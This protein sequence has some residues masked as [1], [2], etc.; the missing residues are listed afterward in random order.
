VW[1]AAVGG[2]IPAPGRHASLAELA[3][4]LA[5]QNAGPDLMPPLVAFTEHV[6]ARVPHRLAEE[7]HA[8]ID[9]VAQRYLNLA[10]RIPAYRKGI[11][12]PPGVGTPDARPPIRPC[13][14]I[15]I[16]KDFIESDRFEVRYWIQRNSQ[17]WNPE[18]IDPRQ[19]TFRQL[20]RVLQ[21]AIEH[22]ETAWYDL[23]SDRKPLEIELLL[24]TDLLHT[25]VEWWH[26]ELDTPA[27]TPLCL[28]YR[29]VVRPLDRMRLAHRR[30]VWNDRWHTLW[31]HPPRHEVQWGRSDP[32]AEGL[33]T[34]NAQLRED[35][36]ITT[37]VLG[38]SPEREA[39]HL[40]L[41]SALNTGIPVILWDH[42]P[43]PLTPQMAELFGRLTQ[44]PPGE[45]ADRV[46]DLRREAA[47]MPAEERDQHIGRRV[48]LLWD[49]PERN[50][51][52]AGAQR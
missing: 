12:R 11:E 45:L 15:Q 26:T 2:L 34:W 29:V 31:Q 18:P 39:G 21:A 10:H 27:P 20:E 17:R 23:D 50:V 42:K 48:A 16:E 9:R 40:E 44:G 35:H 33:D 7:L 25:A 4:R 30:R 43:G 5:E 24:P 19:A 41:Q 22:A 3:E 37:V 36:G 28:D 14:L 51:Y 6:A 47:R 8:W 13:L 52:D 38:D 32:V 1:Q 49:D 46:D